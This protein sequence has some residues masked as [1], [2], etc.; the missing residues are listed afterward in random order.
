VETTHL[1]HAPQLKAEKDNAELRIEDPTK[2]QSLV[3]AE[4]RI[5]YD[6]LDAC[7]NSGANVVLSR[8]VSLGGGGGR[9]V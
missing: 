8:L 1:A 3:D 9:C 5:I 2:Y 7:V 6:K 4:W